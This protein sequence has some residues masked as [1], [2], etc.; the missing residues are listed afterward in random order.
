MQIWVNYNEGKNTRSFFISI[1]I[2]NIRKKF[3]VISLTAEVKISCS[4][5]YENLGP[6][7]LQLVQIFD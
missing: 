5:C 7:H 2:A 3:S 4:R 1:Y 6:F